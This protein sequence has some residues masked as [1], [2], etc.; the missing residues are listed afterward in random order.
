MIAHKKLQLAMNIRGGKRPSTRQETGE[1]LSNMNSE[2]VDT[3][4][5]DIPHEAVRYILVPALRTIKPFGDGAIFTNLPRLSNQHSEKSH[6]PM[7]HSI[8]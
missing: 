1:P 6:V 4:A 3:G 8:A 5:T 2:L 7:T